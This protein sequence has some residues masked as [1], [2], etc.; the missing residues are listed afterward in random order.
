MKFYFFVFLFFLA[1]CSNFSKKNRFSQYYNIDSLLNIQIKNL[2]KSQNLN[3][4]IYWEDDYEE[5]K[6]NSSLINWEKELNIFKQID[7]NKPSNLDA[8]SVLLENNSIEY[9]KF[10]EDEGIVSLKIIF[11]RQGNPKKIFST[12]I[13]QNLLFNSIK[14]YSLDFDT[15]GI[16]I[17]YSLEDTQK[18]IFNDTLE[19]A[20]FAEVQW[21]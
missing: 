6:I 15:S 2:S 14:E 21:N 11:H 1:A 7:L 10:L 18:S 16:L 19:Y 4:V 13:K 9:K 17:K 8:Y 12:E 5:K 20:L 3:K